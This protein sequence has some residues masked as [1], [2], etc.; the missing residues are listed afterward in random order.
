[1]K[2]INITAKLIILKWTAVLVNM[3]PLLIYYIVKNDTIYK[4]IDKSIAIHFMIL[5]FF[6]FLILKDQV[7]PYFASYSALKISVILVS[8][9]ILSR[10]LYAE[11]LEM[12]LCLL[13]GSL[14]STIF[15][16]WRNIL[17]RP[18]SA[19]EQIKMFSEIVD[20]L[21]SSMTVDN[22]IVNT[23]EENNNG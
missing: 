10:I 3:L 12:S 14:L 20:T 11:F 18:I 13:V 9:S 4:Q 23:N 2:K 8:L 16:A 5:C 21:K 17:M 6:I 15:I 1:M 7:K 19:N 22:N